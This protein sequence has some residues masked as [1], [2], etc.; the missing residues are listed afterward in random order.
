MKI[1]DHRSLPADKADSA[2]GKIAVPGELHE[3]LFE[4]GQGHSVYALLDAAD[5][6]NLPELISQ[7]GLEAKCLFVDDKDTGLKDVAPWLVKLRSDDAFAVSMFQTG[8]E[9]WLLGNY[10][11]PVLM[12]SHA[13]LET[14]F[15]HFRRLVMVET[16]EAKRA[17]LRFWNNETIDSLVAPLDAPTGFVSAFFDPDGVDLHMWYRTDEATWANVHLEPHTYD[18]NDRKLSRTDHDNLV[19]PLVRRY[20]TALRGELEDRLG[21]QGRDF[22][23]K[24]TKEISHRL[25]RFVYA[26]A[27]QPGAPMKSAAKLAAIFFLVGPEAE[28]A[29]LRGPV[30]QNRDIPLTERFDTVANSF[31]TAA[32]RINGQEVV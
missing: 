2:F 25:A 4:E 18:P 22:E 14:L 26:A 16:H 19:A 3:V 30:M 12:S 13:D 11:T 15:Q 7:S 1:I 10:P 24:R 23:P 6:T 9:P 29:I 27:G 5:I 32:K 8:E 21:K 28:T 20:S 31:M 17:F